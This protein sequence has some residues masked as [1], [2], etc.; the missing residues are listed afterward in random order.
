M[1][2][3]VLERPNWPLRNPL[4][5][6]ARVHVA[7]AIV[8]FL[9]ATSAPVAIILSVGLRAGLSEA[10]LASWLFAC[11][12]FNG[13]I[14]LVLTL[15][16]RQPLVFFWTIPGTVLIGPALSHLT[17]PEVIGASIATGALM[18]VLGLSGLVRRAMQA[19]PMP[20]VMGMVAGVF[21][22]FGIELV[23]AF[24]AE[25]WIAATMTIVFVA[26]SALP[27]LGKILPPLIGALIAGAIVVW[28]SGSFHPQ[29]GELFSLA[30]PE[31]FA[32]AFSL[33]AMIELV[34]PLAITVLFV[35]NSQGIAVLSASG[36]QPPINAIT[37]A[38]GA[39]SMVTAFFGSVPT[40]LTGPVNAILA[41]GGE[42]RQ[43]YTGAVLIGLLAILFGLIAPFFTRVML[44]T[45][46]AF[47]A[48]LAGLAILRVLQTAF[49]VSFR[50]K[51]SFGAVVCFVVTVADIPI[52]RIGAPFWGLV[53][54]L[55][56]SY[57]LERDDLKDDA[58]EQRS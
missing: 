5:D 7:N 48:T 45:P 44:A 4:K 16:Y 55:A 52:F 36:H 47:I 9:F 23:Q 24:R 46:P 49:Q 20:I 22:R 10:V 12:F 6:F 33:E 15:L 53:F 21:L 26:L 13:I 41:S 35:Q 39:G 14:T 43:Q 29:A 57:L 50:D 11:F 18:L 3:T 40:C 37:S 19:V 38:C 25:F 8:A 56:A 42:V 54:G 28:L 31:L 17:L 27:R 1:S 34:V 32:P 2:R 51:F 58:P 30:R